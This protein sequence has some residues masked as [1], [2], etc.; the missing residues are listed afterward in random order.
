MTVP[1]VCLITSVRATISRAP[2][3]KIYLSIT[4]GLASTF[5]TLTKAAASHRWTVE[6]KSQWWLERQVSEYVVKWVVQGFFLIT[7]HVPLHSGYFI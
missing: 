1:R 6:R 2:C 5:F 4:F 3:S 7:L